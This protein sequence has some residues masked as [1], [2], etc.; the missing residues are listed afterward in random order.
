MLTLIL[1]VVISLAIV[2]TALVAALAI[3]KP[4]VSLSDAAR[5]L[6]DLLLMLGGIAQ[7]SSMP[8]SVRVRLWLLLFYLAVP[9]DIVPDVIPIVGYA[10]DAIL[11]IWTIRSVVR[12]SGPD[13]LE[14]HWR[15]SPE[16]LGVVRQLAGLA[17]PAAPSSG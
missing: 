2:W 11:V 15:G 16:G 14:R 7:D 5:I 13:A 1:A 8:F 6:P 12:R 4:K 3:W 17:P 9:F 10:D